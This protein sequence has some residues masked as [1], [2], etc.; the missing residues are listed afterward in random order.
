MTKRVL[1]VVF[2]W[3]VNIVTLPANRS[4]PEHWHRIKK[5][6]Y[7]GVCGL[8]KLKI[9][10]R[11]TLFGYASIH[12]IPAETPHSLTTETGVKFLTIESPTGPDDTVFTK[13]GRYP[14]HSP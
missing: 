13:D 6:L 8:G 1:F 9:G 7:I 5:E 10:D 4:I 2:G 3:S 12:Y 14:P 11:T